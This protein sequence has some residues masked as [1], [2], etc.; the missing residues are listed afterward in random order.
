M[1]ENLKNLSLLINR[2]ECINYPNMHNLQ[3]REW[4]SYMQFESEGK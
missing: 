1:S 4:C 2:V 3:G